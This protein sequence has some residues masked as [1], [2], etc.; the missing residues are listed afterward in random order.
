MWYLL[1]F[2]CHQHHRPSDLC[3]GPS[4]SPIGKTW[5]ENKIYEIYF[6]HSISFARFVRSL[7]QAI[8][9][10]CVI[11]YFQFASA[12]A[13][14]HVLGSVFQ[15]S[16]LIP[17]AAYPEET[18]ELNYY[19]WTHSLRYDYDFTL[20][21]IHHGDDERWRTASTSTSDVYRMLLLLLLKHTFRN[22]H[23]FPN[24]KYCR[25]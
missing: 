25:I 18:F 16:T 22:I 2:F 8:F 19:V 23:T 14:H 21:Y 9:L 4:P 13:S 1:S 5:I 12:S 10:S 6:H 7:L 17:K 3:P 11:K 24:G 15:N 20:L